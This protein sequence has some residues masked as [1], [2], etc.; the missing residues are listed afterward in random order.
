VILPPGVLALLG[1]SA[2]ALAVLVAACV[3]GIQVLRHWDFSS[4]SARQLA[5][6]RRTFLVSSLATVALVIEVGS[7]LLFLYTVDDL[8]GLFV[9]AMCATGSLNANPVG[10]WVLPVKVLIVIMAPLWIALNSLDL[11]AG[12]FPAI[13]ARYGAL[14]VLAP[15]VAADLVLQARYFAG[16]DPEVI[17]SCCGSLFSAAGSG[18]SSDLAALPVV[19][20][21]AAFY[22][23]AAALL[24]SMSVGLVRPA[25]AV[26]L[27][28]AALAL[29]FLVVA[30]A[31]M[32]SFLSLYIYELPTHHCPFD[33]LQLQYRAI[34]YPLYVSLLA[35][36]VCGLLP[37]TASLFRRR[38]SFAAVADRAE[39]GWLRCGIVATVL[40]VALA[41]APVIFG[42]LTMRGQ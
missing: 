28:T 40:F 17:T 21:M 11:R 3:V 13:R 4:S 42:S 35:A 38:G 19:P 41:S 5:L 20:T 39:V 6:E 16:L 27:V 31:S 33:V 1:G 34:G 23:T 18:V 37:A 14:L 15:L 10:W 24:V 9:G 8:H 25:A 32:V 36:V 22:A 30:L 12:D 2:I 26:R 7:S 29:V